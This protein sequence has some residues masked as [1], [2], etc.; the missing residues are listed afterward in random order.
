MTRRLGYILLLTTAILAWRLLPA[1][2]P[3]LMAND[4]R[5]C[6]LV[7]GEITPI[8][9][10]RLLASQEKL[11][12]DCHPKALTASH[13]TGFSPGRSL[14]A[15]FPLDWKGELTCSTCHSVHD[16]RAGLMRTSL[17][18]RDY[19][20]SCHDSAFFDAMA[21]GGTTLVSSGHL[22]P[23][24]ATLVEAGTIDDFS[25]QCMTCHADEQGSLAV[26]ISA[27]G[28]IN[29]S[30]GGSNHPVGSDYQ[31]VSLGGGY[32]PVSML[33]GY[34]SLPQGRL[35]CVSCHIAYG[36]IHGKLV[37]SNEGSQ[38]CFS[39]HDL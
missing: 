34:I 12:K 9:A 6:H 22:V 18:G 35:S 4:C 37:S 24:L 26:S 27:S 10:G 2:S 29:H 38:L 16:E 17:R 13:P 28:V 30:S 20:Q 31:Q 39:C 1:K 8:N 23:D 3:H 19:C 14:P 25:F 7:Q 32:R 36:D 21:D 33:P 5:S 11:C 15:D